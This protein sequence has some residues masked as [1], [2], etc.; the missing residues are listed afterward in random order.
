VYTVVR[1]EIKTVVTSRYLSTRFLLSVLSVDS[2]TTIV[3]SN[4]NRSSPSYASWT[5]C[6]SNKHQNG[7]NW[8][9]SSN[10]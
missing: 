6:Y 4:Q 8:S 2:T 10:L 3:D 5:R 1:Q 9:R 7:K